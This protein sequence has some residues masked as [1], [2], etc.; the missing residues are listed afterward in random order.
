MISLLT[1]DEML[2]Q[3]QALLTSLAPDLITTRDTDAGVMLELMADAAVGFQADMVATEEDIFPQTAVTAALEKHAEVRLGPSPRKPAVGTDE[4]AAALTVTGT[5]ASV[6]VAGD[7]LVHLDGT[8]YEIAVGATVPAGGSVDVALKSID[9]GIAC[10]KDAGQQLTFESPPVGIASTATLALAMT[11][12]LDAE[13]D[14]ELLARL[15]D[16][17]RNPFAG[18]R[19]SDYRQWAVA[20]PKVLTAY[21]YG[22]SS[23]APEGRS[24]S[25]VG[26]VDLVA[27]G[28]G[29]AAER[30]VD[31]DVEG[32]VYDYV[33]ERRPVGATFHILTPTAVTQ[34]FEIEI[35]PEPGYEFDWTG[36]ATVSNWEPS[37]TGGPR[38]TWSGGGV[39]AAVVAGTRLCVYGQYCVVVS[40]DATHTIIDRVLVGDAAVIGKNIYPGGPLTE[41][42]LAAVVAYCDALGPARG[43][44]YDPFQT[45][46]EDSVKPSK[47]YKA[48]LTVDGVQDADL[49]TPSSN[50][51]PDDHA[52]SGTPD[53]LVYGLIEVYPYGLIEDEG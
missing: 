29:T 6:V 3:L 17:I 10:N 12:A 13:S 22:P 15:L 32:A 49:V 44:A 36:S 35:T 1:R 39:P 41:P 18:G 27:L 25:G 38:I 48:L 37:Y 28:Y 20:V 53:L 16:A 24:G 14:A 11:G 45:G 33:I 21:C 40:F 51:V 8:R 31:A 19:F 42:V 7:S 2:E 43:L 47:I 23:V 30:V 52:P 26:S 46:W 50:V 4:I 9:T 34:A 5:P